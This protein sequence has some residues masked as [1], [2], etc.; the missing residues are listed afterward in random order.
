MKVEDIFITGYPGSGV[1]GSYTYD[2]IVS[3]ATYK[4]FLNDCQ[5]SCSNNGVSL[6]GSSA[7]V[8]TVDCT[9]YNVHAYA[10]VGFDFTYCEGIYI[11]NVTG[12]AGTYGLY[13][14]PSGTAFVKNVFINQFVADVTTQ[15]GIYI[16]NTSTDSQAIDTIHIANS[17]SVNAGYTGGGTPDAYDGI[18]VDGT[19]D[20]I[21]NVK[22]M[23]CKIGYNGGYGIYFGQYPNYTII[24]NNEIFLNSRKTANTYDHIRLHGDMAFVSVIGNMMAQYGGQTKY[25]INV[26]SGGGAFFNINGNVITGYQTAPIYFAASGADNQI[27]GNSPKSTYDRLTIGGDLTVDG[28]CTGCP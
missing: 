2:G 11:W 14:H 15:H 9:I 13:I 8:R 18:R 22:I 28:T 5:I 20:Y 16:Y 25:G 10:G 21:T 19:K 23:N 1:S 12:W 7:S 26:T 27:F 3:N 4:L 6:T 17:W 24:S